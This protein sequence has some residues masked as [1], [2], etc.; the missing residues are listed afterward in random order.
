MSQLWHQ[1][2]AHKGRVVPH[3]A[4]KPQKA[5]HAFLIVMKVW[6]QPYIRTNIPGISVDADV[7]NQYIAIS[8]L[9]TSTTPVLWDAT[10]E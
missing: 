7:D 2:C 4:P 1:M 10:C 9:W 6:R 8:A 5:L 3:D